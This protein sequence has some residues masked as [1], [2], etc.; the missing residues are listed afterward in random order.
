V[1]F[2]PAGAT[3]LLARG[4]A[5]ALARRTGDRVVIDNRPGAGGNLGAELAAR[6]PADGHTFLVAPLTIYAAGT[7]LQPARAFDL[8]RD[9]TP[10]TTLARVPH[11]LVAD[12]GFDVA[13]VTAL[14]RAARERPGRIV[15]ASQGVGTISH[16][17][18]ML[19]QHMAGVEFTH[20]PYKGSA[21]ALLD[22]AGGRVQIMF[23]SIA[24]A[25]PQIRAG[26]LRALAV[27]TAARAAILPASRRSR[28]PDF[29][30]TPPSP[31]SGYSRRRR[32]RVR[33]S[34]G[35]RK[36]VVPSS[37]TPHWRRASPNR[38]SRPTSAR[39]PMSMHSSVARSR[40]GPP[41]SAAP[42]SC[43]RSASG[44]RMHVSDASAG[45]R[46]CAVRPDRP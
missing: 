20:V 41:S 17:E 31:G 15:L 22:L 23:D 44:H 5:D 3:D 8:V 28:R 35:S 45:A 19:F 26:R 40:T 21:P 29:P 33:R 7:T 25:L 38:G 46:T 18:G 2:T 12:A 6:A 14:V 11:V 34:S 9:F 10:V 16:L 27:T 39:V 43:C 1:P 13:D 36:T 30:D 37:R 24:S 42:A 4:F 32:R